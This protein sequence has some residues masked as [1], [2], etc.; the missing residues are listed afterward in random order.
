MTSGTKALLIGTTAIAAVTTTTTMTSNGLG[1]GHQT[2]TSPTPSPTPTPTPTPTSGTVITVPAGYTV[3]QAVGLHCDGVTDDTA[4]LQSNLSSLLSYQALQLPA[5]TCVTSNILT[6]GPNKSNEMVFGA[7]PN[8][9]V[10]QATNP[11]AQAIVVTQSSGIILQGFQVHDPNSTTR[12]SN[13]N[14]DGIYVNRS[15]NVTIDSVKITNAAAAGIL[16]GHVNGGLIQ[17]SEV[18]NSLADGFHITGASQNITIQFNI[19]SRV[20]DDSFASIGY[21]NSG[22]NYNINILNN[23]ASDGA[24]AGG[25]GIEGTV[26]A[27]VYNNQIYRSGIAG[28]RIDSQSSY[29]TA[30]SDQI[31]LQNNYLEGDVTRT[32]TGHGSIM[33]YVNWSSGYA[34]NITASGNQIVNPADGIGVKAFG[35]SSTNNVQASFAT[36]TMTG[37]ATPYSI[38]AYAS[39]T[40]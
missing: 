25:I 16:F 36:T 6:L 7:G 21:L 37:V 38:G 34:H 12:Q 11:L 33:I 19:A 3:K 18:D 10:I 1:K 31:D 30:P 27:K 26:G 8:N 4:A 20:G 13:G 39:V 5:G 9:T 32:N 29:S 14:S 28:I 17:N 2:P 15:S 23:Q 35:Y 22:Q 40:H 24:W